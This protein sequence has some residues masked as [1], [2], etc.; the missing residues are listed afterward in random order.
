MGIWDIG[1][2]D[3]DMA[4]DWENCIKNN[5]NLS[6]IENIFYLVINDKEENLDIDLANKGLGA[7]EAVSRL[8][9]AEGIKSSYTE[10]LDKWVL[11]YKGEVPKKIVSDALKSIEKIISPS[12][13]VYQFWK[14]RGELKNW[15]DLINNLK[16]RLESKQ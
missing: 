4:C 5:N 8:I 16:E 9:S 14:I 7:A 3:N 6:C 2:F 11:N 12:S 1:F 15:I 13:E 10:H